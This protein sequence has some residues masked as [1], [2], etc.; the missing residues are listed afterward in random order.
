[1][2]MCCRIDHEV[3]VTFRR[4]L[5]AAWLGVPAL[6][7]FHSAA[8]VIRVLRSR[9]SAS[10]EATRAL[11]DDGGPEAGLLLLAASIPFVKA[12][13][14]G[15]RKYESEAL[16]EVSI[17]IGQ[18]RRLDKLP[19]DRHLLTLIVDLACD[20]QWKRMCRS[21]PHVPLPRQH[22]IWEQADLVVGTEDLAIGRLALDEVKRDLLRR[23]Y[24][25]GGAV[26]S[27][28]TV[29]R[30]IG[31]ERRTQEERNRLNHGRRK[32]RHIVDPLL[33]A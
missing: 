5:P 9:G 23:P 1:M 6:R 17:V 14:K 26:E 28:N 21:R 11:L 8:E 20:R 31:Q 16:T 19:L 18:V 24:A 3:A 15:N 32:L 22:G 13:S 27:W 4:G 33:V 25:V 2:D 30:L 29:V 7:R 12:W 10:R